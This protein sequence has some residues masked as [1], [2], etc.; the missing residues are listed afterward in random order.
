M[1]DTDKGIFD[2][3]GATIGILLGVFIPCLLEKR[4]LFRD[5]VVRMS[6]WKDSIVAGTVFLLVI[7]SALIVVKLAISSLKRK[8][9]KIR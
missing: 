9:Q 5:V 8:S 4:N 6:E 1:K 3:I 7:T 2:A